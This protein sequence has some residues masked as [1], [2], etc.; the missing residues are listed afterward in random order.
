MGDDGRG[1]DLAWEGGAT[2]RVRVEGRGSD[3]AC[4]GGGTGERPRMLGG[5]GERPRVWGYGV[6]MGIYE[7]GKGATPRGRAEGRGSDPAC[8]GCLK[9]YLMVFDAPPES[10]FL[11][12]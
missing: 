8:G 9:S 3:L 10:A 7:R 6:Y 5:K 1:S 2:S 12:G 4:E 11:M